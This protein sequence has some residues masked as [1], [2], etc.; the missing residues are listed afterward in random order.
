MVVVAAFVALGAMFSFSPA[1]AG[2]AQTHTVRFD[3]AGGDK[4]NLPVRTGDVVVFTIDSSLIA[5]VEVTLGSE[6]FTVA[7]APVSRK[8]SNSVSYSGTYNV[9]GMLGVTKSSGTITATDPPPPPP[10]P[11]PANEEP[12]PGSS[13]P[14]TTPG[15]GSGGG[16]SPGGGSGGSGPGGGGSDSGGSGSSGAGSSGYSGWGG[17]PG[18]GP[19]GS[20]GSA[21]GPWL[22]SGDAGAAGGAG[23]GAGGASSGQGPAVGAPNSNSDPTAV[24]GSVRSAQQRALPSVAG[25]TP[26]GL[27]LIAL[28]GAVLLLGVGI[29]FSRTLRGGRLDLPAA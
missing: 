1:Q 25:A 7:G 9:L 28:C 29:A 3:V 16:G 8:I 24:V 10:P 2:A 13:S 18:M 5:S 26:G 12:A 14:P 23:A 11:P 15:G 6:S 22:G 21:N 20:S 27:L 17:S 19:P 4:G